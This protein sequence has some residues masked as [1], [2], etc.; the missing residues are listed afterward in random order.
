MGEQANKSATI[1]TQA[2]N[3]RTLVVPPPLPPTQIFSHLTLVLDT[4]TNPRFQFHAHAELRIGR[5]SKKDGETAEIL[6]LSVYDGEQH[7][8]SRQ[9]CRILSND[10]GYFIEDLNSLNGT[11]LNGVRIKPERRTR[12]QHSDYVQVGKI[13]FWVFLPEGH[14]G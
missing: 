9:H 8:I 4:V 14:I 3:I 12:L 6:D 5:Q 2:L 13:G 7:S 11:W 10:L 1:E